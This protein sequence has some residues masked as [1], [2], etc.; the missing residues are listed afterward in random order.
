MKE[1]YTGDVEKCWMCKGKG[2]FILFPNGPIITCSL[3]EGKGYL[4]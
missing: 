2:Y 1:D 4:M 3:C